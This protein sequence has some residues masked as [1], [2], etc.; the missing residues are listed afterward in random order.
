MPHQ[1]GASVNKRRL[2]NNVVESTILYASPVWGKSLQVARN[3][4]KLE[5]VQRIMLLRICRTYRTVSTEALQV[6]A[7]VVPIDSMVDERARC[8][9]LSRE[10]KE[11]ERILT[12]NTWQDKWSRAVNG[13]W[14]RRL[15][16]NI[17]PW[18]ERQRPH[19]TNPV[20]P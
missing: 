8:Y 6:I 17:G 11:H 10:E 9:S 14:T 18:R 12:H 4:K 7:G 5:A 19:G 13:E 16:P 15:I 1:G 20:R 2:L 3:R